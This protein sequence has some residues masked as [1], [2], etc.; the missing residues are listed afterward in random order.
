MIQM[1]TILGRLLLTIVLGVVIR[2]AI[3]HAYSPLYTPVEDYTMFVNITD[4]SV[5]IFCLFTFILA[6]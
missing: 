4:L 6:L 3:L 2:F 1:I 5:V